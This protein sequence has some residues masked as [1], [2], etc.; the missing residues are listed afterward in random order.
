MFGIDHC[1]SFVCAMNCSTS[2]LEAESQPLILCPLCLRKLQRAL[3]F[4]LQERYVGLAVLCHEMS[5]SNGNLCVRSGSVDPNGQLPVVPHH[6]RRKASC[7]TPLEPEM[8][9]TA[10]S[11]GK[12]TQ[13][14]Q[15]LNA[16]VAR[17][18]GNWS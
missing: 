16:A 1:R 6:T 4:Q 8:M 3:R 11:E 13:A 15:W 2:V 18:R 12:F 9:R 5:L 17:L 14:C 10:W 7:W